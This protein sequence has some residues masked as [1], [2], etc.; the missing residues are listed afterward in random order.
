M[1]KGRN[2]KIQAFA[3]PLND[4][5]ESQSRKYKWTIIND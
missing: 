1:K 2:L 4:P 3:N 5:E